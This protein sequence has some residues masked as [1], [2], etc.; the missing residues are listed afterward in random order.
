MARSRR[1]GHN[2]AAIVVM[3]MTVAQQAIAFSS[4][5][6]AAAPRG[7]STPAGRFRWTGASGGSCA[8]AWHC[9]PARATMGCSHLRLCFLARRRQPASQRCHSMH[10]MCASLKQQ[11]ELQESVATC[12]V[13]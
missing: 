13:G 1:V 5:A 9:S 6:R 10:L 3:A 8:T 4:Y 11:D 12:Y 2:M 7:C